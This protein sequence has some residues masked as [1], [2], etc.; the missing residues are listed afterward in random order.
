VDS[1]TSLIL[2]V[3]EIDV[4]TCFFYTNKSPFW[5][6]YTVIMSKISNKTK[7]SFFFELH[8]LLVLGATYWDIVYCMCVVAVLV[9]GRLSYVYTQHQLDT[10][11][12]GTAVVNRL[13]TITH[14]YSETAGQTVSY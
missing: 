1:T 13:H 14:S 8:Q 7:K 12:D 4:I 3:N 6:W 5:T 2:N 11:F 10:S 9:C